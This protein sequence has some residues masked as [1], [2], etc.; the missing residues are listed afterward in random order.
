[1]LELAE[2]LSDL[3]TNLTSGKEKLVAPDK[4]NRRH[5]FWALSTQVKCTE[6]QYWH[7]SGTA[8][9]WEVK[10]NFDHYLKL[11]GKRYSGDKVLEIYKG[12][13]VRV[14]WLALLLIFKIT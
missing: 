11:K 8:I 4:S 12:V 7:L 9:S 3:L 1:M 13:T 10:L 5:F 6:S 2:D 14:N